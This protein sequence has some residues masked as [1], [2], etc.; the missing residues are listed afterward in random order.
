VLF[1]LV[2]AETRSRLNASVILYRRKC[3]YQQSPPP[4]FCAKALLGLIE[5]SLCAKLIRNGCQP[6]SWAVKAIFNPSRRLLSLVLLQAPHPCNLTA[7]FLVLT[8]IASTL[9][10]PTL[11]DG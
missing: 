8:N 11:S 9:A 5:S 1:M 7:V 10:P 2:L 3:I 6:A 4:E